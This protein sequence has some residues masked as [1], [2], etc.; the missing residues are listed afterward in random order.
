MA[1]RRS[2]MEGR[3]QGG[4][5]PGDTPIDVTMGESIPVASASF[6]PGYSLETS[7]RR[8]ATEPYM[9]EADLVRGYCDYGA[10]I[11]EGRGRQQ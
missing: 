4:D 10:A 6:D 1:K 7:L 3:P 8:S 11:G 5:V 9:D 2:R